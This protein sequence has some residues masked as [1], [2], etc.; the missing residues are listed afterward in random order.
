MFCTGA[1]CLSTFL[2]QSAL[3]AE[4]FMNETTPKLIERIDPSSRQRRMSPC[5]SSGIK[6]ARDVTSVTAGLT[7]FIGN[8]CFLVSYLIS[9]ITNKRGGKKMK[10]ARK[11]QT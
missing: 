9:L 3:K 11:V 10:N 1:T 2:I 5:L 7:G 8:S 4:E 6:I